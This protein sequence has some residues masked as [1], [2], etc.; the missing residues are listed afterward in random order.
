MVNF[1]AIQDMAAALQIER[2]LAT[3]DVVMLRQLRDLQ[4]VESAR[5]RTEAG[6]PSGRTTVR[7][8]RPERRT[9]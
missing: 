3:A 9:A 1:T 7:V 5:S 8:A 2:E 6:V 4:I